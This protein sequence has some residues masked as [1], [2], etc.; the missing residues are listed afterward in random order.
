MGEYQL[1]VKSIDYMA[2]HP[3]DEESIIWMRRVSSG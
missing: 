3:L 2:R 1:D